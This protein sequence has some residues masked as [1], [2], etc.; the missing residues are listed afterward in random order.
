MHPTKTTLLFAIAAAVFTGTVWA[1]EPRPRIDADG[2]GRI[3]RAEAA[4]HP[5]LVERLATLDRNGDGALDASERPRRRGGEGL[6]TID[7]D[8][9]GRISRAEASGLTRLAGR[10]DTLDANR[11]G[12]IDA[13]ER[14]RRGQGGRRGGMAKLDANRDGR[15]SAAE[16]SGHPRLA[17]R[18]TTIDANRDGVLTREELQASRA[19]RR[20]AAPPR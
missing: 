18:F 15:L 16:V 9:D 3:T 5:R 10:F 1:Q 17:E 11:D 13:S 12:Y 2:D 14:P 4:A 20:R 8:R 6:R 7:A 19:A